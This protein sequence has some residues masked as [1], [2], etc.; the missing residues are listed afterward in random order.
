MAPSLS[1]AG[2]A[3]R[4]GCEI[5]ERRVLCASSGNP[6]QSLLR[7]R[8]RLMAG[9]RELRTAAYRAPEGPQG[10][11]SLR[12]CFAFGVGFLQSKCCDLGFAI[13][14]AD[15]CSRGACPQRLARLPEA[16]KAVADGSGGHPSALR[17]RGAGL[18]IV[19]RWL[20][21]TFHAGP[22]CSSTMLRPAFS[23]ALP[24]GG[25]GILG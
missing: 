1:G 2:F 11:Y 4:A 24:E 7:P 22:A 25:S 12:V 23:P 8:T 13:L 20:M 15:P 17:R 18:L 3:G 14:P 9:A 10:D 5:A 16:R 6:S 21:V 19:H